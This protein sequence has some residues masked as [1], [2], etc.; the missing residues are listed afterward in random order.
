M[1]CNFTPVPREN[2]RIGVPKSRKV[3]EIFNSDAQKYGGSGMKNGE[4]SVSRSPW[5]GFEHSIEVN[6]PPLGVVIF[7]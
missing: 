7:R 6:L 2:Y 5:H 1:A 3:R 4:A